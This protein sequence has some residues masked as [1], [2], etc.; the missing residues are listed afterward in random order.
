M[1]LCLCVNYRTGGGDYNLYNFVDKFMSEHKNAG[2]IGINW[3]IFGSSG[4]ETKPEGG[5]LEN[6][7][8]CA[9]KN[10]PRNCHIK[11][12]CD[13]LKVLSWP[14]AH[15]PFFRKG[16]VNLDE[17]GRIIEGPLSQEVHFEY[18]RINHYHTKSKEEYAEKVKRGRVDLQYNPMDVKNFSSHDQN[19]VRDT[20]ILARI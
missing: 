19:L 7:L 15:D 9:E 11:T 10:F 20:E 6:Y 1:N 17:N 8:M 13:P 5:V 18:I 16:F 12:I 14:I 4:H 3:L 2:G